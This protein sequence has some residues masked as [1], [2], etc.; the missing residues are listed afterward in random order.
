MSAN[1][2]LEQI[3]DS[4]WK[5]A[6]AIRAGRCCEMTGEIDRKPN[7]S[8]RFPKHS[9][10]HIIRRSWLRYR[11]DLNNGVYLNARWH[12]FAEKTPHRFD[13]WLKENKPE[14]FKWYEDQ[15]PLKSKRFAAWE[16]EEVIEGLKEKIKELTN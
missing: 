2:N 13:V 15:Y 3:A 10:H 4:L 8:P 14:R 11:W 16:M 7:G 1:A 6:V 5:E 12:E 9:S